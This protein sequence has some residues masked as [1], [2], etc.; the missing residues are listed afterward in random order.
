M[1]RQ[2]DLSLAR[3]STGIKCWGP[4]CD[5][6]VLLHFPPPSELSVLRWSSFFPPG[7]TFRMYLAHLVKARQLND[8]DATSRYTDWVRGAAMGLSKARDCSFAARPGVS[9]D[10]LCQLV[11]SFPLQ[12]EFTPLAVIG[13]ICLLR[14]K[15]EAIPM[16]RRT[17]AENTSEFGQAGSHSVLGMVGRCLALKLRQRKHMDSGSTLKRPCCR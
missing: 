10:Q 6:N 5:L 13:W 17:P 16:R 8:C 2:T 1:L 11:R 9:K 7:E 15:S 4:F 14:I 3:V 12:D